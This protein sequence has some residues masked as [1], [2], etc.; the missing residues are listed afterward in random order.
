MAGVSRAP[1]SPQLRNSYLHKT[2]IVKLK[3]LPCTLPSWVTLSLRLDWREMSNVMPTFS[4]RLPGLKSEMFSQAIFFKDCQLMRPYVPCEKEIP[5]WRANTFR[6]VYVT[7]LSRSCEAIVPAVKE[8]RWSF[9]EA[10]HGSGIWHAVTTMTTNDFHAWEVTEWGQ[11]WTTARKG[12]VRSLAH[13][14]AN[15]Y[16]N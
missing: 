4:R 11:P 9:E 14:L 10:K 16:N 3:D 8:G 15:S 7:E 13:L 2:T 12:G 1:P 6:V 5:R